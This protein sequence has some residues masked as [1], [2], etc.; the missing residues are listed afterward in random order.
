MCKQSH[1]TEESDGET[2][3]IVLLICKVTKKTFVSHSVAANLFTAL[4]P[5]QPH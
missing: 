3:E 4:S 1:W 5:D 2:K